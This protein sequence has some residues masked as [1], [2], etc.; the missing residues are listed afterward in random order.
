MRKRQWRDGVWWGQPSRQREPRCKGLEAGKGSPKSGVKGEASAA[1]SLFSLI[2][3]ITVKPNLEALFIVYLMHHFNFLESNL[4]LNFNNDLF[5]LCSEVVLHSQNESV[6]N[7]REAL[8]E[9]TFWKHQL[10]LQWS[11]RV[12]TLPK[13]S[14]FLPRNSVYPETIW[15]GICHHLVFKTKSIVQPWPVFLKH[16]T[17][18]LDFKCIHTSFELGCANL[19]LFVPWF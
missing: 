4:L 7:T 16:N 10:P 13:I 14:S 11:E 18:N 19:C 12:N 17:T 8:W 6:F 3:M 9:S 15:L 1:K 5:F 2:A